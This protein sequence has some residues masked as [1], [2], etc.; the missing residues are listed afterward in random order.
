[1]FGYEF[2]NFLYERG[3][4][5]EV[6][7]AYENLPQSSEQIIHPEKYLAGETPLTVPDVDLPGIM[8]ENWRSLANDALG[9]WGTFLL[10][11]YSADLE[12]QLSDEQAVL[13]SAGWGGDRYQVLY[14]DAQDLILLVGHWIWDSSADAGEFGVAVQDYLSARHRGQTL[15][16]PNGACWQSNNQ[17]SCIFE[18][19]SETLWILSPD[20]TSIDQVLTQYPNF[21]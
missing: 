17:I 8:G 16:R 4:W 5:A 12:S 7:R 20:E 21:P 11:G 19:G 15:S 3:N 18:S 1:V 13:A 14:N 9:E 2:V 10:L 6:N